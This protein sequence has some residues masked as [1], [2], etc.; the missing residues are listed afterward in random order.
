MDLACLA[1][2]GDTHKRIAH[3][4]PMVTRVFGAQA[5][6]KSLTHLLVERGYIVDKVFGEGEAPGFIAHR[7]GEVVLACRGSTGL[8]DMPANLNMY[9]VPFRPPEDR[10]QACTCG[11]MVFCSCGSPGD[12]DVESS[13]NWMSRGRRPKRSCDERRVHAGYYGMLLSLL[14]S[15]D[16][17]LLPQLLDPKPE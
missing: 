10:P 2:L 5:A 13:S 16:A 3:E 15:L 11:A 8:R 7:D 9:T 14:P 4:I 17:I 6:G 12:T 1:Y